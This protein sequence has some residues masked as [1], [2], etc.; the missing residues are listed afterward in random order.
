M[1]TQ[2]TSLDILEEELA[3]V[4]DLTGI[5]QKSDIEFLDVG[6]DSRVYHIKDTNTYFKFPRSKKIQGRYIQE[7]AALKLAGSIEPNIA[8][9]RILFE[10]P[11]NRYVGYEGV[12][13]ISLANVISSL[14]TQEKQ[15]IGKTIGSFLRLFHDQTLPGAR[16][17]TATDEIRQLHEWYEKGA[18]K[19]R[20][21]L[22]KTEQKRLQNVVYEEW[23]RLLLN[24]SADP[25]L[26][27]GDLHF[28]NIFLSPDKTLGIID[29]GDVG[30]YDRS[31]DFIDLADEAIFETAI[32][33]Y[34]DSP[35]LRKKNRNPQA[36]YP[37]HYLYIPCRQE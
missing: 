4:L 36:A 15:Q 7:I 30:Y 28:P 21:E 18:P 32:K 31:K 29:F 14:T 3:K 1:N 17:I 5:M 33:A 13:G 24:F 37:N 27:H 8:F 25:G 26:C 2:N 23:P 12:S 11:S 20:E 9:P 16:R 35:V 19:L 6:W 10:D 22:N 34:G